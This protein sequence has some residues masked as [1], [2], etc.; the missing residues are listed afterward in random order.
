[1]PSKYGSFGNV[2]LEACACGTP[3]LVT[4]RCDIVDMVGCEVEYDKNKLREVMFKIL[5]DEGLR[6]RFGEGC[7]R[8]VWGEFGWDKIVSRV[9]E[10]VYEEFIKIKIENLSKEGDVCTVQ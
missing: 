9:E 3:V 8:L 5:S 7:K 6:R 10:E 1:M 2:A 4:D